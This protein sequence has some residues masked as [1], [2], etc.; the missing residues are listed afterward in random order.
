[1]GL[2]ITLRRKDGT[3]IRAIPDPLGGTFDASGD[4]DALLGSGSTPVLDAIDPDGETTLRSSEMAALEREV[5]ALLANIS[6]NAQGPGRHGTAW[7]G[8]TRFRVMVGLCGND[9]NLT[10]HFLGD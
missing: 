6:E 3:V 10:L 2:Y 1:M 4:F 9:D 8:L 7:R 5:D